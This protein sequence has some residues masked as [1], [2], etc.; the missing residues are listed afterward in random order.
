VAKWLWALLTLA[1]V[2]GIGRRS[3]LFFVQFLLSEFSWRRSLQF[4]AI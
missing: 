1:R 4:G 2:G 3:L